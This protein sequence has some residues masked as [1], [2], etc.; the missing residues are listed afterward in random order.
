MRGGTNVGD[1]AVLTSLRNSGQ[2]RFSSQV[3]TLNEE[4][5]ASN[6]IRRDNERKTKAYMLIR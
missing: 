6:L 1:I 3:N 5:I 2:T 4:I